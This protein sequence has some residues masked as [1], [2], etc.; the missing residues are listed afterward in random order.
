V[1]RVVACA[2]QT[3]GTS[4]TTGKVQHGFYVS[5]WPIKIQAAS[6]GWCRAVALV[7]EE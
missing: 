4:I 7:P 2:G 5:Y 3:E 6:I 1:R